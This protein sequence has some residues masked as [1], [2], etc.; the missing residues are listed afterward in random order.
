VLEYELAVILR[1]LTRAST[2]VGSK[3]ARKLNVITAMKTLHGH[4]LGIA[5]S[6]RPRFHRAGNYSFAGLRLSSRYALRPS[7]A[8]APYPTFM[9][10]VHNVFAPSTQISGIVEMINYIQFNA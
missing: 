1:Q 10:I 4:A 2:P 7:P 5:P 3:L 9:G 8:Q 6:F